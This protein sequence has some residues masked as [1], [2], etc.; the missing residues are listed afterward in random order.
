MDKQANERTNFVSNRSQIMNSGLPYILPFQCK[1]FNK[2]QQWWNLNVTNCEYYRSKIIN[3]GDW[4]KDVRRGLVMTIQKLNTLN[5]VLYGTKQQ[6][7]IIVLLACTYFL[8]HHVNVNH[9][10]FHSH[11]KRKSELSISNAIEI[12]WESCGPGS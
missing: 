5:S 11:A 1:F 2:N 10:T 4:T 3:N 6:I 9:E 7:E 8:Q 12:F